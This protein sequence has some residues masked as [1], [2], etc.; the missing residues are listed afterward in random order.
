MTTTLLAKIEISGLSSAGVH[1][2]SSN[3]TS[4]IPPNSSIIA[5]PTP[6]FGRVLWL[7][8]AD[9]VFF[10][11]PFSVKVEDIIQCGAANKGA[12]GGECEGLIKLVIPEEDPCTAVPNLSGRKDKQ[13]GRMPFVA[14]RGGSPR[15][16]PPTHTTLQKEH[17]TESRMSDQPYSQKLARG[18]I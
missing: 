18:R 6:P 3:T 12:G 16:R 4:N 11:S 5:P 9:D 1:P 13:I 2:P 17:E 10:S 8:S 7:S 15:T 14:W